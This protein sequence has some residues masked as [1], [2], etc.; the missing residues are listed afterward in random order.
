VRATNYYADT[1][2]LIN[3]LRKNYGSLWQE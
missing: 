3:K 2:W 1:R